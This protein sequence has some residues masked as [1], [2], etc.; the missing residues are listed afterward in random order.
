[1]GWFSKTPESRVY[2]V[3]YLLDDRVL[4]Q[5]WA[6]DSKLDKGRIEALRKALPSNGR[7]DFEIPTAI[8]A[9][10]VEATVSPGQALLTVLLGGKPV[11]SSVV[12][13]DASPASAALTS[14]FLASLRRT[15]PV[16][17]FVADPSRAYAK[18]ATVGERP[19]VGSVHW[20][21]IKPDQFKALGR[22]DCECAVALLPPPA[23]K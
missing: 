8:G 19:M 5:D 7:K 17:Q 11:L 12:Q 6:S 16:K 22:L 9:V 18:I 3:L 15:E 20:P 21:V 23:T 14:E 1:M 10:K 2:R 13:L 4:E